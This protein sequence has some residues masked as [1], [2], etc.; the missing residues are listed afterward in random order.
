MHWWGSVTRYIP[1]SLASAVPDK[2]FHNAVDVDSDKEMSVHP[3]A[4]YLESVFSEGLRN[5]IDRVEIEP[6]D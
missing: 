4:E 3:C 1:R 2:S 5:A 6:R